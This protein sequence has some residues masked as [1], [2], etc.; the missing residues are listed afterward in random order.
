M[1]YIYTHHFLIFVETFFVPS[2][3]NVPHLFKKHV[4]SL[5]WEVYGSVCVQ[6]KLYIVFLF[7]LWLPFN[8]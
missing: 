5:I 6:I 1:V 4:Y 8:F 2:Y 7:F 3:V